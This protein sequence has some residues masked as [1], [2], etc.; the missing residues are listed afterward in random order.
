MINILYNKYK[1]WF[2]IILSFLFII[3]G[4]SNVFTG[5]VW[6]VVLNIFLG[7]ICLIVAM[8]IVFK[9]RKTD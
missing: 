3:G 4:I 2:W 6:E 5:T 1:L 8:S 9:Q 7:I